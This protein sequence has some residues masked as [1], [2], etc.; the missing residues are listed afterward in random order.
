MHEGGPYLCSLQKC[1]MEVILLKEKWLD[2]R[3]CYTVCTTELTFELIF[4]AL[5]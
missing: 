1:F 5:F 4:A 3:L 2:L